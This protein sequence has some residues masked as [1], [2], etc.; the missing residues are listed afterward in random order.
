MGNPMQEERWRRSRLPESSSP[1]SCFARETRLE[2][3]HKT[4]FTNNKDAQSQI[5]VSHNPIGPQSKFCLERNPELTTH[6]PT[7]DGE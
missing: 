3:D 2:N 5:L 7:R 4:R 1:Q 6:Y